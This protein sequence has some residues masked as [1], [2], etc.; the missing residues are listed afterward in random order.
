MT[1]VKIGFTAIPEDVDL[2]ML[3]GVHGAWVNVQVG[4]EFL[5]GDSETATFQKCA[6]GGSGQA[7]AYGT[8]DASGYKNIFHSVGYG[9]AGSNLIRLRKLVQSFFDSGDIFRSV[10]SDAFVVYAGY[11]D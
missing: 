3:E 4:V 9:V 10:D 7:F 11:G 5:E 8:D 6:D 1:E 2:T